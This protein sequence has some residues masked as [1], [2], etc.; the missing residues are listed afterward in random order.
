[1]QR[2]GTGEAVIGTGMPRRPAT[3]AFIAT[4]RRH[5]GDGW[6][7]ANGRQPSIS[8]NDVAGRFDRF[9]EFALSQWDIAAGISDT[10]GWWISER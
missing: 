10:R 2:V 6:H 3:Q 8:L 9:W 1:V 5:E 4:W 7:P